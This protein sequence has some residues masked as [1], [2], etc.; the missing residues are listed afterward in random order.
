MAGAVT[1]ASPQPNSW[2]YGPGW[3]LL[4][5][6]GGAYA[7]LFA[8][9]VVTGP[10]L[11]EGTPTILVP[12]VALIVGTPHYGATLLRVYEH[13]RDR[14]SY[15]LFSLWATLL[16]IAVFVAGLWVSA[17]GVFLLTLYLSW[18]P[19]HYTG[20][21]YGISVMFLRRNK[22][23]LE[24]NDKRWL[25]ATFGLSF[26]LVLVIMHA[27]GGS[28]TAQADYE[29]GAI[30]FHPLGIPSAVVD[31][32]VPGLVVAYVVALGV[33]A[34]RLLRRA[35]ARALAPAGL[36][37]L[38]Q[39][40][41]FS[42]PFFLRFLEVHPVRVEAL[43]WDF[44]LHYF[45]WIAAG[46]QI[47]YLWVTSYYARQSS[48]W[49]GY[50]PWYGKA[51]GAGAGAWML[52]ALLLGPLAFGPLSMDLGL[53]L[54]IASAV[55]VH[56]FILDGAIWKLKGRIAEVLIRSG[57]DATDDDKRSWLG[58]GL[59]PAVWSACALGLF[60]F[61]LQVV[62]TE[63]VRRS[64]ERNDLEA[65]RA[66]WDRLA[67]FGLDE[68]GGRLRL[69]RGLLERGDVVAARREFERTVELGSLPG[70]WDGLAETQ[71]RLGDWAAA[72]QTCERGLERWPDNVLL[73][74]HGAEAW[75]RAGDPARALP[76]IER[77]AE[78]SPD[79]AAVRAS[80]QRI[81]SAASR[82]RT[83]SVP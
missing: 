37:V 61:V 73:L 54:L 32:L 63:S 45:L 74:A 40:L 55:N 33:V 53:A 34:V 31:V 77:A 50:V 71:A 27:A 68:A 16:V 78:L 19:W 67:L 64:E 44:R 25:Y 60:L 72:A 11:R 41:W 46:H 48:G 7:L 58:A 10:Y 28:P 17:V 2:L 12:L 66:G 43:D 5:G 65:V 18:S 38:T 9:L 76:L 35:P 30:G 59:R 70:A 51:L 42:I 82:P 79:N 75:R 52:P 4:L 20:Q 22:V 56:H 69:A 83:A 57:R 15:A 80:L 47:Q 3:D 29:A 49:P 36:L 81:R 23:E 1:A 62:Q 24:G 6:C 14:R 13:R 26:L 21:N 8:L 39:A